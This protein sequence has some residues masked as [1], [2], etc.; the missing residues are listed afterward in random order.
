MPPV[1]R[2]TLNQ[3]CTKYSDLMHDN[4]HVEVSDQ[5]HRDHMILMEML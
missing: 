2:W 3:V 1:P 4:G 5:I